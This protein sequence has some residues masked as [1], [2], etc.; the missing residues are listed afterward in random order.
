MRLK[1]ALVA[2]IA[3]GAR[4]GVVKRIERKIRGDNFVPTFPLPIRSPGRKL[5]PG[6][7]L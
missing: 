5:R 4:Q 1:I 2:L 3:S 7:K 6:A